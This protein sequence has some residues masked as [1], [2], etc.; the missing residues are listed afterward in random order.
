MEHQDQHLED[1]LL[2]VAAAE[3]GILLL[4]QVELEVLAVEELEEQLVRE[5]LEP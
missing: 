4:V 3:N 5:L 1:G 2:V